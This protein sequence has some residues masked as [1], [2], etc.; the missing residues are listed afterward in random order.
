M[1]HRPGRETRKP[2]ATADRARNPTTV[3][4]LRI[5]MP[6]TTKD[7]HPLDAEAQ[8]VLAA[9]ANRTGVP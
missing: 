2:A 6:H 5:I 8:Q 9:A 3:T 7:L 1:T 4:Y